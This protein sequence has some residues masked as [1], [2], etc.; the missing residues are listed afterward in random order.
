MLQLKLKVVQEVKRTIHSTFVHVSISPY[1]IKGKI[2]GGSFS[3]IS[4]R[5]KLI[6]RDKNSK[7]EQFDEKFTVG[8]VSIE[9][10]WNRIKRSHTIIQD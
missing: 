4:G 7:E 1:L 2:D 8:T 6:I 10:N 9:S 3:I 5:S